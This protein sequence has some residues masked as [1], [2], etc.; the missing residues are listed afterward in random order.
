MSFAYV[1]VGQR[2]KAWRLAA[3]LKAEDVADRL[4]LSRAAVYRLERGN[5]VKVEVLEKVAALLNVSLALLMG[6]EV[7]YYPNA[8]GFFERMCQLEEHAEQ[9]LAH[10]EPVSF[11][12]T[13]DE[14][15]D[16]LRTMLLEGVPT[17]IWSNQELKV[18]EE[19]D[20]IM[21][22]LRRRKAQFAR[23]HANIISVV[24]TR[25]IERFIHVG[26]VGRLSLP[27]AVHR[28][29]IEAAKREVLHMAALIENEPIGVQMGVVDDTLP[30]FTFQIFRQPRR[31]YVAVSAFRL[32]ELPNIR[33]GVATV[34]ASDE[35]VGLHKK[36][37]TN[38]W[39]RSQ[40]GREGASLLRGLVQ[41][42]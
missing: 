10:F 29:R 14:Y 4:G 31:D 32:G 24:G 6:V 38:L 9:I 26:V 41:R 40:K 20:A 11:L 2:L 30:P 22:I 23:K 36:M 27:R 37:M 25:E 39:E 7:E 16:H 13:S 1:E 17:D 33:T 19:V 15:P 8:V 12:L 5:I 35:A 34:S 42:V 18:T 3:S 21:E 28:T